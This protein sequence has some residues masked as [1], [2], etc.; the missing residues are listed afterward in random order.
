MTS[1]VTS[2]LERTLTEK[3]LEVETEKMSAKRE[4]VTNSVILKENY[5]ILKDSHNIIIRSRI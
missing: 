3:F 5:L 4:V 2:C 1:T